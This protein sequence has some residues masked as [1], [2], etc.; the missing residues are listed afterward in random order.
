MRLSLIEQ[1]RNAPRAYIL[2]LSTSR[3]GMMRRY[4]VYVQQPD[5]SLDVLWPADT[6][7]SNGKGGEPLLPGMVHKRRH[8]HGPDNLPAYHYA[9]GGCGFSAMDEIRS[10]LRAINP[11]I[12]VASIDGHSPSHT[13]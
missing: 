3:S 6:G 10:T 11:T 9:F 5:G 13:L 2:P 8:A 12:E 1:V 4:A 7:D